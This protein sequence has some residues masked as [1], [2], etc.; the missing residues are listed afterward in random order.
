VHEP[1]AEPPVSPFPPRV[2]P[3]SAGIVGAAPEGLDGETL[4]WIILHGMK[5]IPAVL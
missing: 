1:H 3:T 5:A 2:T 4:L